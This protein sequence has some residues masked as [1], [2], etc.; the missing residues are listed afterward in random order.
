[1]N[2]SPCGAGGYRTTRCFKCGNDFQYYRGGSWDWKEK[3][4]LDCLAYEAGLS[5]TNDDIETLKKSIELDKEI[6]RNKEKK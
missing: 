4:C 1:M 6:Q 3:M 5:V 2:F